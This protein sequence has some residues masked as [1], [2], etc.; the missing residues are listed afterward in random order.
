MKRLV[1]ALSAAM[2]MLLSLFGAG[3]LCAAQPYVYGP[4]E[5][6]PKYKGGDAALIKYLSENIV[7]PPEAVAQ[8]IEGRVVVKFVVG[9][10]GQARSVEVVRSVHPLLDAEAVRVASTLTEFIPGMVNGKN[11]A[12]GYVL[13]ISFKL[14]APEKAPKK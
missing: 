6:R 10:D 12:W 7:Y 9:L 2:M 13:P 5:V 8:G 11:V 14:P 4:V 1:I 3:Q